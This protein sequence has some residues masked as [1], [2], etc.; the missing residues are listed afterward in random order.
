MDFIRAVEPFIQTILNL[1]LQSLI[2]FPV[3]ARR[4]GIQI[5]RQNGESYIDNQWVISLVGDPVPA[6]EFGN[7][8]NAEQSAR[9]VADLLNAVRMFRQKVM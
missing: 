6:I 1:P 4:K 5:C 9:M 3:E 7:G 2:W 8:I